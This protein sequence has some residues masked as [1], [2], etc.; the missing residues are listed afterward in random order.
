MSH[1]IISRL[2]ALLLSIF[3]FSHILALGQNS[4]EISKR[5]PIN[6][7]LRNISISEKKGKIIADNS[8]WLNYTVLIGEADP[9]VSISVNI[10]SGSLPQGIEL[11]VE[12]LEYRG[13]SRGKMGKP[14]GPI[15]LSHIP[16]VLLRNIGTSYSGSGR[17]E[18][19]QLLFSFKITD[20]A[21]LEPGINTIY[22]Q[23]TITQ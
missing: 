14:A 19:H 20:F 21:K 22:I 13:F 11:N 23:Y 12:A 9:P 17:N 7:D 15:N 10:E 1:N 6:L 3:I 16:K 8:Q 5:A 4:I 18:G 2:K